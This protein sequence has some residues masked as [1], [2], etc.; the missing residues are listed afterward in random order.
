[1]I[2]TPYTSYITSSASYTYD[3][4]Y[5]YYASLDYDLETN[6]KKGSEIG[7]LYKKRCWEF[8]LRL[9]ENIRPIL[10]Q[11]GDSSVNDRYLYFTII[12]K[13]L[14]S[15][16]SSSNFAARLPDSLQGI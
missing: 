8:G 3:D 5:S 6:Y 13:P 16:E 7:F 14:M 1:D 11:S 10:T 2:Y 12:L 9:L 4:H 15:P